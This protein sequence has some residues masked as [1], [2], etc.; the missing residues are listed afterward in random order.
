MYRFICSRCAVP[1]AEATLSWLRSLPHDSSLNIAI[2][3]FVHDDDAAFPK[4]VIALN[5]KPDDRREL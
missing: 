5:K 4:A 2:A 1:A 3:D